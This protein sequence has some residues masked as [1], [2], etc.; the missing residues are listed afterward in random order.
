MPFISCYMCACVSETIHANILL[1]LTSLR[2]NQKL[3]HWITQCESAFMSLVLLVSAMCVCCKNGVNVVFVPHLLP[4]VPHPSD[5]CWNPHTEPLYYDV[6]PYI[7]LPLSHCFWCLSFCLYHCF[8]VQIREEKRGE[9]GGKSS[10]AATEV[11]HPEW[12]WAREDERWKG[13]VGSFLEMIMIFC[14]WNVLT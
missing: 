1:V 12:S 4:T 10:F 8:C 5:G 3:W 6:F 13:K 7:S 11:R 9:K 14:T 2:L